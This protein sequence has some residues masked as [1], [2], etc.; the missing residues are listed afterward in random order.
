MRKILDTSQQRRIKLLEILLSKEE[1]VTIQSLSEEAE[2]SQRTVAHDL[3]YLKQTYHEKLPLDIS[4][5]SGVKLHQP[6]ISSIGHIFREIFHESVALQWL[7]EL[8]IHPH[9]PLDYYEDKLFVSSSTLLRL[10]PKIN[11][12]LKNYGMRIAAVN[13]L[14]SFLG[15]DEA[16][17]RDFSASF[18]LELH[19]LDLSTLDLSLD[20]SLLAGIT[21]RNLKNA[22][23]EEHLPWIA[24]DDLSLVYRIM[25]YVVSLFREEH[26]YALSSSYP[27]ENELSDE[28]LKILK[29]SFPGITQEKLRGTHEYLYAQNQGFQSEEEKQGIT[30]YVSDLVSTLAKR[31]NISMEMEKENRIRFVILSIYFK[32]KQRSQDTS[33]LFDRIYY[34]AE[35]IRKYNPLLYL[36]I[37][38]EIRKLSESVGVNLQP[39]LHS[40]LFW[41]ILAEPSLAR[42]PV[43]KKALLI[44]DFGIPHSQYLK[45]SIESF[46]RDSPYT[47]TIDA[48]DP[49]TLDPHATFGEYDIILTTLRDLPLVHPRIQTIGDYFTL[50]DFYNIY[51]KLR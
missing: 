15:E 34:F 13:G 46:F 10:L 50:E 24:Q 49:S 3:A 4:K 19:G 6:N 30:L 48:V 28:E 27:V 40:I 16:Y 33:L 25:F 32:A 5:K 35:G 14:Y 18:L 23:P 7:K 26:G 12:F 17:L 39:H 9:H 43:Q 41:M 1:F 38:E 8:L 20:L 22:V 45:N 44:S 36:V 29:L 11:T 47:F 31:L 21:L 51:N 37:E 2:A 42:C